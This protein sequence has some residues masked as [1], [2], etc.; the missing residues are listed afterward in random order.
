MSQQACRSQEYPIGGWHLAFEVNLEKVTHSDF[1]LKVS[2]SWTEEYKKSSVYKEH[3]GRDDRVLEHIVLD[4]SR[5]RIPVI[6]PPS[7]S[8]HGIHRR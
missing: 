7:I 5:T 2:E 3:G 8:D 6:H 1:E 4:F